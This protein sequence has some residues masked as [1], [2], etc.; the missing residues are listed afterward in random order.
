MYA[1]VNGMDEISYEGVDVHN[2]NPG[3]QVVEIALGKQYGFPYC[4]TA[5]R[6]VLAGGQVVPPGTQL[7]KSDIHTDA[8]CAANSSRPTTFIQ[9]HSAPLDI[10]F[11][12]QHP[13]GAL[14]ERYRGGAFVALHGSWN[15]DPATGYKVIWIPFDAAGHSPMPIST[16]TDTTFPYE[17]VLGGGNASGPADGPWSWAT[18]GYSDEPRFADVAISPIDGALYVTSDNQGVLYRVGKPN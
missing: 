12:D 14:P 11:F 8:W 7:N 17:V 4:W 13:Q 6:V 5:Q 9:A 15:R 18:S 16:A 3:E 2:D 10:V 1:V